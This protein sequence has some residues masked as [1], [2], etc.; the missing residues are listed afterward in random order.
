MIT[1]EEAK[2]VIQDIR[3]EGDF[4]YTF[5]YY[6]GYEEIDDDRFHELRLAYLDAGKD[7][8]KYL[9]EVAGEKLHG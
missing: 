9:E 5:E 2:K 8:R 3:N 4:Q 1:K 7:L 6:S